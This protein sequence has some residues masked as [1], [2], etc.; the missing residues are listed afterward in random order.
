MMIHRSTQVYHQQSDVDKKNVEISH[1]PCPQRIQQCTKI[2]DVDIKWGYL[3][4]SQSSPNQ[5]NNQTKIFN[6]AIKHNQ[7][8]LM[9]LHKHVQENQSAIEFLGEILL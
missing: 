3:K 5:C 7:N 1:S 9:M 8:L 4:C 6:Y 2:T